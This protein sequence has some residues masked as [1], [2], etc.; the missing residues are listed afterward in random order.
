MMIKKIIAIGLITSMWMGILTGC[1]TKE[2]STENTTENA[3]G[4]YI[5]TKISFSEGKSI[6]I[7][8]DIVACADG[9]IKAVEVSN[10]GKSILWESADAGKTWKQVFELPFEAEDEMVAQV[11][12]KSDGSLICNVMTITETEYEGK[13]WKVSTTGEKEELKIELPPITDGANRGLAVMGEEN[14]IEESGIKITDGEVSI[15]EESS[16]EIASEEVLGVEDGDIEIT[17]EER[18][19]IEESR[20]EVGTEGESVTTATGGTEIIG[21]K[22]SGADELLIQ[23]ITGQIYLIDNNTGEIMRKYLPDDSPSMSMTTAGET[24]YVI[25][26]E[27]IQGYDIKTGESIEI[28]E[29]LSSQIMGEATS[30]KGAIQYIQNYLGLVEGKD[31]KELY[32]SDSTGIYRHAESG[33]VLEQLMGSE[34]TVLDSPGATVKRLVQLNN[35][36]FIILVEDMSETTY[37][38]DKLYHY[39]YD[40]DASLTAE[41]E[42]RVYSL[43]E[44]AEIRQAI[45]LYQAK[46][47]D[48]YVSLEIG[49]NES[50]GVTAADAINIL[51]TEIMAGN[52]PDILVLDGM[53]I[54]S[55]LQKG[56]LEDISDI[57]ST[58]EASDGIYKLLPGDKQMAVA[59]RFGVPYLQGDKEVLENVKDTKTLKEALINVGQKMPNK[60]SF[61]YWSVE[62]LVEYLY[63]VNINTILN[64]DK[65]LN[66]EEMKALLAD[67]KEIKEIDKVE[68]YVEDDNESVMLVGGRGYMPPETAIMGLLANSASVSGS[69]IRSQQALAMIESVNSRVPGLDYKT[70]AGNGAGGVLIPNTIIG[71]N[72]KSKDITTAKEF[73]SFILSKEVQKGEQ[74]HGFAVNKIALGEALRAE[75][76]KVMLGVMMEKEDGTSEDVTMTIEPPSEEQVKRLEEAIASIEEVAISDRVVEEVFLEHAVKYLQGEESLEDAVKNIEQSTSLYLAE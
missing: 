6:G 19:S 34:R 56:I 5:E 26:A 47:N 70:F 65:T 62:Q 61:D 35:Q 3:K 49:I 7:V 39:A 41:K 40:E 45:A 46:N 32:Y 4:R 72:S 1:G 64:D 66:I 2:V 75:F 76:E 71:V 60:Q 29:V 58:I 48:I 22:I 28:D 51:N 25:I 73:V 37:N 24:L 31:N 42:L 44:N 15:I 30:A 16:T 68:D 12:I 11:G 21:L 69:E 23:D 74:G 10:E 57:V 27:T 52:G 55:Y 59:T 54:E 38:G 13:I 67:I 9:T 63:K 50:D 8:G 18:A 53:P 14:A 17:D 20:I 33:K 36:E 43:E